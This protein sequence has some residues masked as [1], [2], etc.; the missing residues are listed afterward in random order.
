M[1][2]TCRNCHRC[3]SSSLEIFIS[4]L[5]RTGKLCECR[6]LQMVRHTIVA[7]LLNALFASSAGLASI[8]LPTTSLDGLQVVAAIQST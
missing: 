5:M 4:I 2:D 8:C 3:N 7:S 6:Q 1:G